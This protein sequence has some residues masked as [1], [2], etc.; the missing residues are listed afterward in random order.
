MKS[1]LKALL[2]GRINGRHGLIVTETLYTCSGCK[3]KITPQEARWVDD[4]IYCPV[5]HPELTQQDD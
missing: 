3:A 2:S 1:N 4:K 5:C